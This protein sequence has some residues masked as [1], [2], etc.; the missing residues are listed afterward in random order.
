MLI[1]LFV[2]QMHSTSPLLLV[3]EDFE[4][5]VKNDVSASYQI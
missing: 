1:Q 5:P 4:Y 2:L 3:H